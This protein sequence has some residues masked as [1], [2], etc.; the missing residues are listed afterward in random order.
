MTNELV[1]VEIEPTA[2]QP[3]ELHC[4]SCKRKM[5]KMPTDINIEKELFIRLNSF[6]CRTCGKTYLDLE[7]AKKLDRAMT[8]HRLLKG[9]FTLE[10]S[11][12]FDGD[13]YIFRIP[14]EFTHHVKK[15]KVEITPLGEKEFCAV[16]E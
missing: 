12:S 1:Q 16:V 11:L 15:R 3:A 10:R 4:S 6:I 9:G 7:E 13:N 14:K 2:F 8:F 5:K